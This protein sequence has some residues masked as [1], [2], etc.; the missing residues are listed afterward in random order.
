MA[1][2]RIHS[3]RSTVTLTKN[4]CPYIAPLIW[5]QPQVDV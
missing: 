1:S 4:V 2:S 3:Y 5:V